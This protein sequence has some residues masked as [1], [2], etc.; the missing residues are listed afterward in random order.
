MLWSKP[1]KKPDTNLAENRQPAMAAVSTTPGEIQRT[2]KKETIVD[3]VVKLAPIIQEM[4]PMDCTIGV[5]DRE[6]FVYYLPGEG[7]NFGAKPGDAI[8]KGSG[9]YGA[10]STGRT[11]DTVVPKEAYGVSFKL[12]GLPLKD[13]KGQIIGAVAFGLSLKNQEA[14]IEVAQNVAASTQ[15]TSATVEELASSAQQ[16]AGSQEVLENLGKEVLEQVKKT[17]VIL[18]F[19]H[20][21]ADTSNLLGLNAA[22]EAAR[23]GDHGRGFSVVAEEIRKLSIKSAQAVKEIRDILAIINDKVMVMSEKVVEAAAL[24][25]EQAAATEEISAAMQELS[26]S[27]GK[28]EEVAS[29]I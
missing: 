24:S 19:I 1:Q 28:L 10:V 22:I 26:T 5:S 4:I 7:I 11:I 16:L 15:Q 25:E 12:R 2:E 21:V 3:L 13:E 29:V 23:A 18:G 8:P 9:L 27:A 14:L 17:D 6:K 20:E